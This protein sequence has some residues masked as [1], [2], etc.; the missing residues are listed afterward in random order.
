VR[1]GNEEREHDIDGRE[2]SDR[3]TTPMCVSAGEVGGEPMRIDDETRPVAN[4][5]Q[6]VKTR[7]ESA[8]TL[9]RPVK[10]TLFCRA[11]RTSSAA[12]RGIVGPWVFRR[13]DAFRSEEGLATS[14][15]FLGFFFLFFFGSYGG[16][17]FSF[18]F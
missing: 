11:S 8:S 5:F 14:K 17:V 16:L 10:R 3:E 1:W 9:A 7:I 15:W 18:F 6:I 13:E 2:S 12:W 4:A